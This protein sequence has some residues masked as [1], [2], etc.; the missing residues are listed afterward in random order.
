MNNDKFIGLRQKAEQLLKQKGLENSATFINDIEK[1]VE[2]LSIYHIELEMQNQELQNT[3]SVL[4]NERSKY[5]DMYMNAPVAYF[6]LNETG[7]IVELNHVAANLL[8]LPIQK[9][10][11]TSIFPYIAEQSKIDFVKSFKLFFNSSNIEYGEIIFLNPLGEFIYTKL[12]AICYF[13]T[14]LNETL[15][16]CA[17]TDITEL[18]HYKA[19]AKLQ[20]QLQE[21]EEKYRL[22]A[23]NTS[24]GILVLGKDTQILYTS[25]SY[26]KMIGYSIEEEL[27]GNSETI[28][29]LIHPEDRDSLFATIFKAME[30][31]KT[32]LTYT[33]RTKHKNGH[34]IWREDNARFNFDSEGNHINTYVICRDITERKNAE[35]QLFNHLSQFNAIFNNAYLSYL[36]IDKSM[37]IAGFNEVAQKT[38]KHLYNKQIQIGDSVYKV[39]RDTDRKNFDER[40]ESALKGNIV[41]SES[42]YSISPN[43]NTWLLFEYIPIANHLGEFDMVCEVAH[44]I[45][46]WK[47]AQIKAQKNEDL[48]RLLAENSSDVIWILDLNFNFVYISPYPEKILGFTLE[49]RKNM[50]F[51][52]LFDAETVEK[53]KQILN[54]HLENYQKNGIV[55]QFL[56]EFEGKHKNGSVVYV[57]IAA[58]FLID[59]Q[60][61]VYAIQG[62]SRDITKRKKTEQNLK[63]LQTA[64]ENTKACVVITDYDG[65]IE[66]ANPYFTE[67]TGYSPQEYM[68]KNPNLLQT[69]LHDKPYYKNLWDTIKLGQTWE[70]E[71]CNRKKNGEVYWENA[72]ISPIRDSNNEITH[73]VAVKTDITFAKKINEELIA[74]KEKAEE[75][76]KLKTAFLNNISHEVRTPLNA[77]CGFSEIISKLNHTPDEL[78]F[79]SNI[80]LKSS[81]KLI[82]IITD[83]I[84]ISQ[85]Q[86]NQIS[87]K[88]SPFDFIQ[89]FIDVQFEFE[90]IFKEKNL[91][92]ECKISPIFD[93]FEIN[94]DRNKWYKIFKHLID[95]AIKFT[96]KGGVTFHVFISHSNIEFSISDTGIGIAEEMQKIIFEP[97]R[98]V[99]VKVS[100]NYGGNG[101]GLAIVKGFLALLGGNIHLKSEFNVGSTFSVSIPIQKVANKLEAMNYFEIQKQKAETILIVDDE[102]SN[103][104]YLAEVL[105][106]ICTKIIH[107]E[108]GQQ[109]IDFCRTEPE[110]NL[111]LMD[112]KMPIMDGHTATKLI[113][114]FRP[115]LPII[116]QSAYATDNNT[117]KFIESGFDDY[118]CKPIQLDILYS[119]IDK[120]VNR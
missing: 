45:T 15:C 83:V 59:T 2:E 18:K 24:D 106:K 19:E 21:S 9:F 26:K 52:A 69:D 85:L 27:I 70:G 48:Y 99:E 33:F 81:N 36:I 42:C 55:E 22:I 20:K 14:D 49:E 113:K 98:Q 8:Q 41:F 102:Y 76:D 91:N 107:A 90:P 5:K 120:F 118:I 111:V 12:N 100:R 110:I 89:L 53:S 72:I 94:S 66:Y 54:K 28:Y 35:I 80:I 84:E 86:S 40:I 38:S 93:S 97:F 68:G 62:A 7:N 16:R 109:A 17:I 56:Y 71:F 37:T 10:R 112:I 6:T 82:E 1:L 60:N 63:K 11:Y 58:K 114:A 46:E 115:E 51:N 116:A 50:K 30:D 25:P 87:I 73:F 31:K 3:N 23:E 61:Q 117:A 32:E 101:V 29:L 39:V 4:T 67:S 103:F 74:A 104:E 34:Y 108:N 78:K 105:K 88:N 43:T 96:Y 65:F 64:I 57:E 44:D 95:N 92:F 119:T 13:D 77:I 47:N 79:F 75:G